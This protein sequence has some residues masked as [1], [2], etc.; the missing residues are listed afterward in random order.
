VNAFPDLLQTVLDVGVGIA[1][2]V[3]PIADQ[4]S[5][6]IDLSTLRVGVRATSCRSVHS[7]FKGIPRRPPWVA[8]DRAR[9]TFDTRRVVRIHNSNGSI[10]V[11]SKPDG[12]LSVVKYPRQQQP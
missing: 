1:F 2:C 4:F 8:T 10:P 7:T 11:D 3:P 9:N 6:I 12:K 5:G